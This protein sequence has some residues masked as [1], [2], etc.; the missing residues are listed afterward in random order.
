[1]ATVTGSKRL[2]NVTYDEITLDILDST[3][4]LKIQSGGSDRFIGETSGAAKMLYGGSVKVATTTT[5]I[6]VTGTIDVDNI[7][8]AG[9]TVITSAR[10]LQNVTANANIITAGTLNNSRLNGDVV[11]TH[12]L[13]GTTTWASIANNSVTNARWLDVVNTT[14]SDRPTNDQNSLAYAYGTGLSFNAAG[15]GALQIYTPEQDGASNGGM[16]YRTG[17]N[18]NLRSWQRVF[19]DEYHPNADKW[20]TGRSHTVTLTGQVTGT[21][22]QTVDG[23]ANKTWTIAT[24][25]NDSAL[26][27]QYVTVGSRYTG[28]G[29]ALLQASKASIRLWDVSTASDDPSGAT[30]GI[31]MTAGWDSTSWGVQQYHDFHSNDLYLRSK[32]NGTWMS[33]WDRVF[34][35]TYHPNA[36]KWTTARTIT[37]S[38]DLSG[39]VS[40]D[41]STNV[42]LSGQVANDSHTHDGRYFTETESDNRYGRRYTGTVTGV[43]SSSYVTAFTVDGSGLGSSIRATFVGTSN[44]VVVNCVADIL[45]NHSLDIL[46]QTLSGFYTTLSIKVTSNNNEDFAVEVKHSG[47]TTTNLAVEVFAL[48]NESVT[49]ASSHSFTGSSHEHSANHGFDISGTGG[50]T[51]TIRTAGNVIS[52]HSYVAG[53]LYHSG[54]V[55]TYLKFDTNRIRLYAGNTVKFDSNNTYLTSGSAVTLSGTQAISGTK[56]FNADIIMG[57][58]STLRRSNHHMGHLEGSYNNVGNN[59]SKS[60]PIYTIGSNYNPTDAALSNMY[61]IGYSRRDQA[62]FLSSFRNSSWGLYVAADG[63]ARIFLNATDGLVASTGGYDVGNT[64]VI[65]S[66][67]V[68]QNVTANASIITAGTFAD[69]RIPSLNASKITAG[70]F[71][72]ARIPNLDASKITTGTLGTA[73]IPEFLEEKYIF[74][75]NDSNGVFMP[76]VKGGLY[77]TTASTVTGAIKVVLPTYKSNMMFTIYVDI[78][79]YTTGETCT[80]RVSGYAY[81]DTGATWHNCSVVAITDSNQDYTVR[82]YSDTANSQQ[83]FTIGET[84]STWSF[85]QVTLRDFWGGYST[86][87]ADAQGTWSISF[88]TSFAGT[89]RRTHSDNLPYA[90]WDRLEGKPSFATVATS[91]SY[92]DLSNT[93]TIPAAAS[94]ATITLAAGTNLSGGGD[95]TTNQS[96]AETITFNLTAPTDIGSNWRDVVAWSGS[97][98]V[99]DAAVEIHGSGYLRATYLN[100]THGTGER[101][102][103]TI[104]YSS[105][106]SYIRKTN[107][108]GFRTS[109]DVYSK[110]E[111]D[112]LIP[113]TSSFMNLSSA[114]TASGFKTFNGNLAVA[115]SVQHAGDSDTKIDFTTNRVRIYAGNTV[116]FDSN[117][118]YLT[119]SSGLNGTNVTSG[120]VASARIASLAASKITSGTFADARIP[121]LAASK[122]TSGTFADARIPSLAASKI[123]SGTFDA[124]RIPSLAASKITS[125]TFAAARIPTTLNATTFS[126][127][128][129]VGS[130]SADHQLKLYKA[131]NNVSDHLQ[132]YMG[133]TRVG[134]IGC[135]DTTW[136]R[137]NQHTNKNIYTPRYIR[138]DNGF[139]VDGTTYGITGAAKFKAQ[140]GTASAPG[141]TFGN[142]SNCGLYRVTTDTVGMATGGAQR[143]RWHSTGTNVTGDI[144]A[145]GN[146]TAYSDER[147]KSDIKTASSEAVYQMRGAAFIKDGKASAGVIAQ[148]I[149]RVT[150]H[151]VHDQDDGYKSVDYMGITAYLIEAVKAQKETIDQLTKRIE[152]LENGNY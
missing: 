117:N 122:I 88:V 70:T 150:P 95:F 104:F 35:D 44:A 141:I 103:D 28:N 106:D 118:T 73:R 134:E 123:T 51:G 15:R 116:K 90:D 145:S 3:G 24:T 89:L 102:T 45:V 130:S 138:A 42:T 58:S 38:G 144:T 41:G 74:N 121:S 86:S 77:A 140:N 113:S 11:R 22:S 43:N 76:M 10:V 6:D 65:S 12:Y 107:A 110:S 23:S 98:L 62:T 152:E 137:I 82:F 151:L 8:I 16:F 72:A 142:D 105:N 47:S 143:Q 63:D 59:A 75:S 129:T 126:G 32:Q 131:D 149:E 46:I 111:T 112:A 54:D 81:N 101:T 80:F 115:D 119:T 13:S 132:F 68:L 108:A 69:G 99:K 57:T 135:G 18:G 27:D 17:W 97:E 49:F 100:M 30:D 21:A 53:N 83:Y 94:N 50:D 37:L 52:N 139:Y 14:A 20:T 1:M 7:A 36:D 79:E 48:N 66:A 91:G 146:I 39:S 40:L 67:R 78:F 61:G 31:V 148:E 125:G 71:T 87:E 109:L 85:P 92:N 84:S 2:L 60:N 9:A 29:S 128:V 33:T 4:Q 19:D 124:A 120:T 56:T 25:L 64:N 133:T 93:P 96:G 55:D 26:D 34:H 5:G 147:L 127:D 136:L 114:Q